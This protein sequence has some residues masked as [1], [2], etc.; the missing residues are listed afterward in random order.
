MGAVLAWIISLRVGFI[1]R[2]GR[3]LLDIA[4]ANGLMSGMEYTDANDIG[5]GT[6]IGGNDVDISLVKCC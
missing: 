5:G 2:W 6:D 4:A 3:E 1:V